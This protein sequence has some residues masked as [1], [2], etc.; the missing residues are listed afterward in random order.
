LSQREREREREREKEGN[1]LAKTV[2]VAHEAPAF[3][4]TLFEYHKYDQ[5]SV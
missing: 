2:K 3:R 5:S 1:M 4:G